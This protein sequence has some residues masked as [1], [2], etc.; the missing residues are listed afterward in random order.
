[1]KKPPKIKKSVMAEQER[2]VAEASAAAQAEANRKEA[3]RK[4]KE[5]TQH[6]ATHNAAT[7]RPERSTLTPLCL[8]LID[9]VR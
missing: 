7:A 1:M 8:C 5:V 9:A 4:K 2:L 6:A 3:E